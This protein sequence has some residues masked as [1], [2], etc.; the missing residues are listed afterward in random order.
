MDIELTIDTKDLDKILGAG[1]DRKAD[2]LVKQTA[3][4]ITT[5]A[6]LRVQNP[7]KS[8]NIYVRR[9]IEHQASAP[10]ESPATDLGNLIA[11]IQ[12]VPQGKMASNVEVHAEYGAALEFGATHIAPRPYLTPAVEGRRKEWE[13]KL[14]RLLSE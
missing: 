10:G 14:G 12:H 7:P 11:S 6:K 13:E 4:G 1:L 2:E 9:G 3:E 5:D 8:G